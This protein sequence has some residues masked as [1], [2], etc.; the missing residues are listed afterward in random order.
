MDATQRI[1]EMIEPSVAAL[2][3]DLVRIE[4]LGTRRPTLQI[5]AER[6]DRGGMTVDDCALLSRTISALL[7]VEDPLPGAY[8]LEVSSPG[9]DRPLTRAED[10]DRFAG[11]EARIDVHPPIEGR[12][13]FKGRLQ[14]RDGGAVR[15]E[16]DTGT[17][18]LELARI[19]RAKLLLTDELIAATQAEEAAAAAGNNN[20]GAGA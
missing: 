15:L 4:V 11:F 18:D 12:K 16:T 7:D 2:G 10:Y 13:R 17:V 19:Q 9:I 3:Y 8:D 6:R 1:A 5:M 20:D 14:G